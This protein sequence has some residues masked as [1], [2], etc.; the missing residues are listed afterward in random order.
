[1]AEI[2]FPNGM[3][4][5]AGVKLTDKLLIANIDTGNAQY[6]EVQDLP[7]INQSALTDEAAARTNADA[8]LQQEIAAVNTGLS[9][10]FET[11]KK[12]GDVHIKDMGSTNL[13][14]SVLEENSIE[15]GIYKYAYSSGTGMAGFLYEG[16]LITSH[17]RSKISLETVIEQTRIEVDRTLRR[18]GNR[19]S[20]GEVTWEEWKDVALTE[21]WLSENIKSVASGS[22][23]YLGKD[24]AAILTD[25]GSTVSLAGSRKF[26]IPTIPLAGT[27]SRYY[28]RDSNGYMVAMTGAQ[29]KSSLSVMD[30]APDDGKLY[31]RKNGAWVAI[32]SQETCVIALALGI[33]VASSS[34]DGTYVVGATVTVA[35]TLESGYTFTGWTENGVIVS[36]SQEY[37]FTAA[38]N[39]SLTATTMSDGPIVVPIGN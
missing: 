30:D 18:K 19:D 4:E 24:N 29:M 37:T 3:T 27:A 1:M 36:S 35:V 17:I 5:R 12:D 32:S 21:S 15:P 28:A 26:L 38:G 8:A 25:N 31:G 22:I 13:G 14:F 7:F 39:R 9:A 6:A 10:K 16:Y 2:A 34:G 20:D 11:H 23:S 33:G